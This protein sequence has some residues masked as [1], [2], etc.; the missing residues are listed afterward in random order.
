M[1]V[2]D[3]DLALWRVA[4]PV[5]ERALETPFTAWTLA[6][7][8]QVLATISE[9]AAELLGH[10]GPRAYTATICELERLHGLMRD[11]RHTALIRLPDGQKTSVR[12]LAWHLSNYPCS[13]EGLAIEALRWMAE[14][15]DRRVEP[16]L[17]DEVIR[18][19]AA[20]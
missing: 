11:D 13:D 2:T 5:A 12:R 7:R 14:H 15:W 16:F 4:K 17:P 10:N 19:I 20:A 18:K 8:F 6:Y 3:S 9:Y 1:S